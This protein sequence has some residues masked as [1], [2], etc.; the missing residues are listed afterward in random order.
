MM[1]IY[2]FVTSD[3][4][5]A[6]FTIYVNLTVLVIPFFAIFGLFGNK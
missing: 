6:I 5:N 3:T 1:E 4:F 2:Q